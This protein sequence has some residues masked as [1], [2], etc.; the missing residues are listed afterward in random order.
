MAPR[1]GLQDTRIAGLILLAAPTRPLEDLILEQ[2]RYLANLSGINQSEEI[3]EHEHLVIKIKN[4]DFNESEFVLGAP[5]SYWAD[6]ATYDPVQESQAVHI[7]LLILQGRRDYQVTMT[8]FSRWNQTFFGNATVALKTYASLNHLFVSG[9]GTP[10]NTEYL[11][12]GHVDEVVIS[13][14]AF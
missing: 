12:E 11:I 4:L 1:I 2:T 3:R 7:P 9:T 13:D 14:I 8:D 5:K 10:T 6:L